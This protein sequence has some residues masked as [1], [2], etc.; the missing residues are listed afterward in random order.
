M[1]VE[2]NKLNQLNKDIFGGGIYKTKKLIP[3][4]GQ[5]VMP[6]PSLPKIKR[7]KI[8]SNNPLGYIMNTSQPQNI[9]QPVPVPIQSQ[10][11]PQE[12]E[13]VI[14]NPEQP[15]EQEI[16]SKKSEKKV[17]EESQNIPPPVEV[18]EEEPQQKK[19]A[20]TDL[21][22]NNVLLPPN[23]STDDEYLFKLINLLNEPRANFTLAKEGDN[24]TVY[25][26]IVSIKFIII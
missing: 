23:Y 9:I 5:I 21:G 18:V 11:Q 17:E 24:V 1:F 6:D 10:I 7:Y 4:Y 16:F 20:I 8:R 15:P 13:K 22:E 2:R 14:E 19:Y 12:E 26:R 25:K 3:D